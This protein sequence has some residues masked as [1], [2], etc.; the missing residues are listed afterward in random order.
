V[1]GARGLSSQAVAGTSNLWQ[2]EPM[3]RRDFVR[4]T[5]M[6]AAASLLPAQ[7]LG[8]TSSG[9]V[10]LGI[11]VLEADGFRALS[12]GV[13]CG[14]LTHPA[15]VS[16]DGR[17]TIDILARAPGVRLTRLFGPEHG[18]DGKAAAEVAIGTMRDARTGLPAYSLYGKTRRPTAE[19]LD[20]LDVMVVDLQDIGSRSY[21]YISCMR[22]VI[23]ACFSAPRP[24]RVVVLDR[25]NPLGGEKVDGPGLDARWKSYVGAY[26]MPYVHGL[27]IGEI[28]RWAVSQPGVLEL[29]E[30]VR[31]RGVLQV[32]P[33]R[34]WR[35]EMTWNATGL[36][37]VA[38]S[39]RIPSSQAAFGYAMVGLGCQLGDFRHGHGDQFPFRFVT[40]PKRRAG[41]I[42]QA[43][44]ARIPGL[45]LTPQVMPDGTQGV[46]TTIADW[47]TFRPCSLSIHLLRQACE[48]GGNDFPSATRNQRD[49]FIKHWGREAIFEG[50]RRD[51][52]R[53]DVDAQVRA[54]SAECAQF[55]SD[56]FSARLY[57]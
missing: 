22:Y 35:R 26:P 55:R 17:R 30:A 54:W 3:D 9:G 46:Y 37:W 11:D 19:M 4:H 21:T 44:G 1:N 8:A 38:T 28:A 6:L 27:T 57:S 53:Y 20:G 13:R 45:T 29:D 51:G 56:T 33:M 32:V 10:Q 15:G 25:P 16:A 2:T 24:I 18:I 52:A 36:P 7:A 41:D 47:R 40:Y 5:A 14:L 12:G 50:F 34:G 31:R 42:V 39:P 48:W 43:L 23:E 49:L